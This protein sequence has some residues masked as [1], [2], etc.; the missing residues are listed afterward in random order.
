[1]KF[2]I[3]EFGDEPSQWHTICNTIY[4]YLHK[5]MPYMNK[6]IYMK[7][8]PWFSF[9]INLKFEKIVKKI[10]KFICATV[11]LGTN[12]SVL[13]DYLQKLIVIFYL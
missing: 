10:I 4:M 8:S 3:Y 9:K 11:L 5:V 1:M 12:E 7:P 2:V 13:K 6:Y